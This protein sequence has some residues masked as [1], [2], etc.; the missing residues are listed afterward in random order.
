[1]VNVW[2]NYEGQNGTL[3][4]AS[5]GAGVNYM[6]ETFTNSANTLVMAAYTVADLAVGYRVGR[7]GMRLNVNNLFNEHYY[8]NAIYANQFSP[9]ATRNFLVSLRYSL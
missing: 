2:L 9:G 1:M 3:N 5:I 6:G 8:A 7:I 4:G